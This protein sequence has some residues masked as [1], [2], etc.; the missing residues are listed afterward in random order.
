MI[1]EIARDLRLSR[2]TVRKVLRSDETSFS[3]ERQVQPRPK[4]RKGPFEAGRRRVHRGRPGTTSFGR[5]DARWWRLILL[6]DKLMNLMSNIG[7]IALSEG[8]RK[9]SAPARVRVPLWTV[10][11][12]PLAGSASVSD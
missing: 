7:N 6:G 11:G 5:L 12:E 4:L 2:N 10:L 8:I 9:S 3:Y 1:K